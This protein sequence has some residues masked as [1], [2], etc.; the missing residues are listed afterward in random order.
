MAYHLHGYNARIA[1]NCKGRSD[2]GLT[3]SGTQSRLKREEILRRFHRQESARRELARDAQE[4]RGN[5]RADL[6]EDALELNRRPAVDAFL[7]RIETELHV[8]IERG[9]VEVEAVR[10]E[11]GER[12]RRKVAR[13]AKAL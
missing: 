11:A 9:P 6:A 13:Q 5:V 8:R 2:V 7:H 1:A 12:R 4:C 3:K 10:V